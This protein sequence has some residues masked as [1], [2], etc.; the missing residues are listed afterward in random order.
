M[1]IKKESYFKDSYSLKVKMNDYHF[2]YV[3]NINLDF[4]NNISVDKEKQKYFLKRN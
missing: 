4:N 2:V 1:Y 3:T